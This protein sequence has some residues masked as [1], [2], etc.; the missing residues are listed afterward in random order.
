MK[1]TSGFSATRID[2]MRAVMAGYVERGEAPGVV[3]LLSR[4]G[5]QR[6]DVFG[7]RMYGGS[8]PMERDTIFRLAS[9]TKPIIAVATMILIEECRLRLDDPVD[10]L[11]PE[12]ANRQVL[13]TLPSEIDDTVPA[14]RPITVR[15]LLT[16]RMGFGLSFELYMGDYPLQRAMNER[17]LGIS[18]WLPDA[19]GPDE[20]LAALGSLP[21]IHQ[22]GEGWLYNTGADVLGVLIARAARQP[23]EAFLQERIFEPLGMRDTAFSVPPAQI[24][25][26]A[27]FYTVDPGTGVP[28]FADDP[29]ASRWGSPPAFAS[30]SAGLVSTAPDLLA[31]GE[32]ML[33]NGRYGDTR[34]LSRPSIA[35]MTTNQLTP[36]QR[37]QAAPIVGENRGW[38]FGVAVNIERNGLA[39]SPGRYGWDGGSGTSLAIDPAEGLIGVLLT[40]VQWTSPSGPGL[41]YDF[42]TLAY[43]AIDD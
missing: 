3:T 36:A 37:A 42:W 32:M 6:I 14:N 9:I 33:N 2:R 28:E 39:A 25:R 24:E 22:P 16:F 10:G 26:L 35:A 13:R 21:L 15:D 27:G 4:H 40:N 7:N 34:I 8:A 43:G 23:L 31:F 11:L 19:T 38:G 12:L 20:W 30:G 41:Y 29:A 5:E 17:G 18:P 1:S